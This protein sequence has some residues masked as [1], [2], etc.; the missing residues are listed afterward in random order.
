M[1][2]LSKNSIASFAGDVLSLFVSADAVVEC[3]VTR[4]E[5]CRLRQFAFQVS[6]L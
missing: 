5:V 2:K 4:P 1:L 6:R 3:V